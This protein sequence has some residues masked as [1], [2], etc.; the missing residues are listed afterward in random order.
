MPASALVLLLSGCIV[1]DAPIQG[2]A[3]SSS[4]P[5]AAPVTAYVA[6]PLT[7]GRLPLPTPATSP[8]P[9]TSAVS[10]DAE[11]AAFA[12]DPRHPLFELVRSDMARLIGSGRA[13]DLQSAYDQAV[14]AKRAKLEAENTAV[15]GPK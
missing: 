5:A 8:T 10:P 13:T 7:G 2:A 14:E 9:R 1:P 4:K 6:D 3:T 12:A 11:V 15:S